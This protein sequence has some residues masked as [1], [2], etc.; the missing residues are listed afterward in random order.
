M[1]PEFA[2]VDGPAGSPAGPSPSSADHQLFGDRLELAQRYAEILAS[3]GVERG[4]IGPREAPRIWERHILN[5]A[6]VSEL[7]PQDASLL[8]VG[9]GAGLPGLVLAIARPDL[10]VTLLEPLERR[11]VFLSEVVESLGLSS[12]T[13]LRGRAEDV[14]RD[15]SAQIVTARAVAPLD[16]LARWCLPLVESGGTLLAIKGSSAPAEIEEH[17]GTIGRLGG[18]LPRIVECGRDIVDP[19]TTVVLIPV[20][21]NPGRGRRRP[22]GKKRQ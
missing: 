1:T 2:D 8:D 14:V 20:K 10:T 16:R 3:T 17:A 15:T 18:G 6:V 12:V 19:P 9:S 22:K 5:C 11:S 21:N 7:V 13:V 4:L